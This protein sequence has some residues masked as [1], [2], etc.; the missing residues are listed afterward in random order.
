MALIVDVAPPAAILVGLDDTTVRVVLVVI[1]T[2]AE[3][4]LELVA[5]LLSFGVY[6]ADIEAG[7]P[8]VVAADV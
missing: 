6:E 1:V 3:E 8:A 4:V 5:C 2:V 7:L